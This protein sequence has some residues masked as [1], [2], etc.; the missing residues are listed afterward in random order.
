M[1]ETCLH[2]DNEDFLK[3]NP[4]LAPLVKGTSSSKGNTRKNRIIKSLDG[5]NYGSGKE[6]EDALK[7]TQAVMAGE[8]FYYI[9]DMLITLPSGN[10]MRLD[11]VLINKKMQVE[12]Y[13]TKAYDIIR[14]KFRCEDDWEVKAREFK[15]VYGFAIKLI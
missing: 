6:A 10:K 13:D 8:Y 9:H 3:L 4:E 11:H 15:T 14:Q 5:Q 7:F 1:D 2:L 12:V